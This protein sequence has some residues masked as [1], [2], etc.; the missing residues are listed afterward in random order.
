[1]KIKDVITVHTA[2]SQLA[3]K[4]EAT[5]YQFTS[6]VRYA[7]A[8]NLRL[9][10]QV[11]SDVENARRKFFAQFSEGGTEIV[12][13]SA[14]GLSYLAEMDKLVMTESDFI[15]HMFTM[16]ELDLDKNQIPTSIVSGLLDLF[17]ET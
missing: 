6:K 5:P 17:S 16:T 1:M 7:L 4:E 14:K 12:P 2:L 10:G 13:T 3:I 11:A 15:P 9:S 8:K